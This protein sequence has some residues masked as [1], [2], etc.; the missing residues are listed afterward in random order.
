MSVFFPRIVRIDATWRCNLNCKHCQTG[1]FRGDNHPTDLDLVELKNLYDQLADL[2][3][4]DIIFLGGE[5]LL[6]KDLPQ[7][8]E[9]LKSLGIKSGITTNGLLIKEEIADYL[10]NTTET[11][12]TV[13][14]DGPDKETHEYIRG[15]GTFQKAV[16]GL[17]RVLGFRS[18]N[19]PVRIGISSV[20]NQNNI[21]KAEEFLDLAKN[22]KV[23]YL[24]LSAVHRVGNAREH[25][26]NLSIPTKDLLHVG[27]KLVSK[28]LSDPNLPEIQMNFLTPIF[29]DYLRNVKQIPANYEP[30]IDIGSFYECYIQCDGKVFPSQ[31]CSEMFPESLHG[32]KNFDI[33]FEEN[34]VKNRRFIDIWL[35]NDFEKY[36]QLIQQKKHIKNY[37]S[38]SNCKFSKTY[39]MPS[40]KAYLMNQSDPYS[41]CT[42]ILNKSV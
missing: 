16:T 9:Y 3:T 41:I 7:Q 30:K 21:F 22:L 36:R 5:P 12:V 19:S 6:R 11:S 8:L 28:V 15:T 4:E 24:I 2:G 18:E 42:E 13:S 29:V 17:E 31:Q 39:C 34:S 20:L 10:M 23:D 38:C 27:E 1:M 40:P 14:L 32:I 35:G 37:N 26:D 25:W 33:K